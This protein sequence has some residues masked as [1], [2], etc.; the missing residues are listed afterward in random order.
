MHYVIEGPDGAGKTTLAKELL[1]AARHYEHVTEHNVRPMILPPWYQYAGML[2]DRAH[3]TVFDRL[4][5][6]QAVYAPLAGRLGGLNEYH[7]RLV[8]RV[9][10]GTGTV[11]VLLLPPVEWCLANWR[12]GDL[13]RERVIKTEEDFR[14]AYDGFGQLRRYADYVSIGPTDAA[15]I[16]TLLRNEKEKP[17]LVRPAIGSP[18]ARVLFIG[19]R[20][21]KGLDVAFLWDQNSSLFLNEALAEAGIEEKDLAVV[22]AHHVNGHRVPL[23]EVARHLPRLQLVVT[24]GVEAKEAWI[25]MRGNSQTPFYSMAHP[26]YVRRFGNLHNSY[27]DELQR[28]RGLLS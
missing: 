20:P 22:D 2:L 23:N 27:V 15:G 3:P 7:L 4:H 19:D 1:G 25:A 11:V 5:L 24:L 26:S 6:S 8:Q 12:R 14:K 17:A 9:V 16:A 21:T 28:V 10:N 18:T 13:A